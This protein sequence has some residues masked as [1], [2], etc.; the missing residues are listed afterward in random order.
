MNTLALISSL[1][2]TIAQYHLHEGKSRQL[3]S[4]TVPKGIN[5]A[6]CQVI[7][8]LQAC[9]PSLYTHTHTHTHHI[10]ALGVFSAMERPGNPQ[11]WPIPQATRTR[12]VM[13]QV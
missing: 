5:K 13:L 8:F 3:T 11:P 7:S 4:Q 2:T 1:L 9:F 6:A 10:L 12:L